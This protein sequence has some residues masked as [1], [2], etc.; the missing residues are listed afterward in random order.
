MQAWE[1]HHVHRELSEIGI[2]LSREPEK[3]DLCYL[4]IYLRDEN[5]INQSLLLGENFIFSMNSFIGSVDFLYIPE[6]SRYSGHGERDQM[7]EIVVTRIGNLESAEA[8]VV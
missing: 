5:V 2:Q 7:I 6:T 8:D 1:G 3:I 4:R